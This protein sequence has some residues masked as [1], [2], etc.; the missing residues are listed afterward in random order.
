[1]VV[2]QGYRAR[3]LLNSDLLWC[4]FRMVISIPLGLASERDPLEA[5]EP[6]DAVLDAGA[7]LVEG[8]CEEGWLVVLV[9]LVGDDGSD[10]ARSRGVPIGLAGVAFV[11]D[12]GA[13]LNVGPDIEQ[14]FEMTPVEGFAAGQVE[15]DYP[16]RRPILRGFSWSS[17]H[18][19]GRALALLAPF[20]SGRRHMRAHDGGV[21]HLKDMRRRTHGRERVEEGLEDAGLAQAVEASPHAVPRTKALRQ[22]APANVLDGEEMKRL[23]ETAVVR[24]LPS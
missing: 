16:R 17:R 12:D 7:G 20:C 19:T 24:G 8:A 21:E 22:G 5:L 14:G 18:A 6:S 2:I 13:G 10:A 4:S 23:E 15:G 1:M 11:A 3:T 9:G